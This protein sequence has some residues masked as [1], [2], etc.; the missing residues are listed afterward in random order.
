MNNFLFLMFVLFVGC[1]HSSKISKSTNSALGYSTDLFAV[2]KTF[3]E[4][5]D[6]VVKSFG[7]ET[8]PT[9]LG[10][11]CPY[12]MFVYFSAEAGPEFIDTRN[13]IDNEIA[14]FVTCGPKPFNFFEAHSLLTQFAP[15]TYFLIEKKSNEK[16]FTKSPNDLIGRKILEVGKAT[17]YK[18]RPLI[19]SSINQQDSFRLG[20]VIKF[21]QNGYC[22]YRFENEQFIENEIKCNTSEAK[23]TVSSVQPVS[24]ITI[25]T[26]Q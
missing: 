23:K 4:T 12:N 2:Y 16:E 18:W 6:D 22:V 17:R 21:K 9:F 3:V 10:L 26:D 13:T 5:A 19:D 15:F 20:N 11:S 25:V 14:Y 1:A 8:P 24:K 7:T